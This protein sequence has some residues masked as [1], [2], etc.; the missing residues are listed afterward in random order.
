MSH[1]FKMQSIFLV[2]IINK[3]IITTNNYKQNIIILL[4]FVLKI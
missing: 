3:I 2:S 1:F 4:S